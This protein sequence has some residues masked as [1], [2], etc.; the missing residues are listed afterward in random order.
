MIN[1]VDEANVLSPAEYI[2][3]KNF[4][5]NEC[6]CTHVET[7][8]LTVKIRK[9]GNSGYYGYWTTSYE[10]V[11]LDL[12]NL[13]ATIVLNATYLLTLEQLKE[14]LAHEF[15]HH[16]TIGYMIENMEIPGWFDHRAPM[17]YYRM[18]GLNLTD[19]AKDYSLEWDHCDKEILAEDYKYFYSPFKEHR[20]KKLVGNPSEE[21]KARIWELGFALRKSWEEQLKKR[22][23]I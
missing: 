13:K 8:W 14:T 22:F 17:D 15:G 21:V 9:D 16:W 1:L 19:F 4:I 11:G 18:R 7:P 6:L 2:Q 5:V 12:K 10:V 3:L 23:E 20:M